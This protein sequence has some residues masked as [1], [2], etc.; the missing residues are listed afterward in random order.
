LKKG[1]KV[2]AEAAFEL[3]EPEVGADANTPHGQRQIFLRH[4]KVIIRRLV[5]S[6]SDPHAR[7]YSILGCT[8]TTFHPFVRRFRTGTGWILNVKSEH[9]HIY[10]VS[11]NVPITRLIDCM[12][13]AVFLRNPLGDVSSPVSL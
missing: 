1:T 6:V 8:Q 4:G 10:V 7:D 12:A 5:S 11:S 13:I 9:G 2:Y 3:R